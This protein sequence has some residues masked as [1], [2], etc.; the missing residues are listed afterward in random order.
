MKSIFKFLFPLA[1]FNLGFGGDSTSSNETLNKT[2]VRDMRVVGGNGSA[3]VSATDST[4]NVVNTD[5]GAIDGAFQT[6]DNALRLSTQLVGDNTKQT[7]A[8]NRS[9]FDSAVGV[10]GDNA[11]RSM[12]NSL[13]L[14]QSVLGSNKD[15]FTTALGV[16]KDSNSNILERMSRTTDS[17]LSSIGNAR[18]DV[19]NAYQDS[20]TPEKSMLKIAGFVVVGLA[21]VSLIAAKVK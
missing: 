21:A 5:H 17:A 11:T 2:E 12:G 6:V 15:I 9:M 16:I 10:V 13:A 1:G 19:A 4:I 18:A 3:N 8:A 7:I 14:T 20:K